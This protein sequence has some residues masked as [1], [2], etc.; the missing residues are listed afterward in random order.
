MGADLVRTE[1]FTT[2][3]MDGVDIRDTLR[4]WYEEK[5][6]VK[7]M[8]P[9]RGRLDTVV[10]LFDAPAD[11]RDYPWRA[12]WYAEHQEE[13]TLAFFA[14]DF[15]KELVGPGIAL[16]TYGGAMMIFPPTPIPDI[17]RNPEFD[18]TETL[19]ERLLAAACLHSSCPQIALLCSSPP[20]AGWRRLAQRYGK[21][22]VHLPVGQFSDATIQ[23]M[24]M[25]HVLNGKQVRS[26][27]E[28]F[29]RKA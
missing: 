25:V 21:K 11:P 3:I 6:F 16:A 22:F 9:S 8:P 4:H 5:I 15:S 18:F 29:I 27:A 13:S 19:E 17:W 28:H 12:T 26:Y 24:R 14:T 2:S 7:I 23:Q 20:G 1:P 10:M